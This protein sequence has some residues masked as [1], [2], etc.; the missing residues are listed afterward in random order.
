MSNV[1]E[2]EM[3]SLVSTH[4]FWTKNIVNFTVANAEVP[5]YKVFTMLRQLP[6]KLALKVLSP[7]NN[8]TTRE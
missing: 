4:Y 5:C 8:I 1:K 7:K 6:P 2:S 3:V